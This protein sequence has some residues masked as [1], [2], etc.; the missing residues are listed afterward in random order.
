MA[1]SS[2]NVNPTNNNE[3]IQW[4]ENGIS[5]SHLNYYEYSVFQNIQPIGSGRF[6]TVHKANLGNSKV[7]ALKSFISDHH[8]T[9]KSK[10]I[11]NEV[12]Y[13]SVIMKVL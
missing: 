11:V 2:K 13:K 7:V 5:T 3:Y 6:G 10:E 9:K 4:I 12:N 1:N 8:V